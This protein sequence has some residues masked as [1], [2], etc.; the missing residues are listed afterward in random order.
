[1]KLPFKVK[2]KKRLSQTKT[3]PARNVEKKF[4]RKKENDKGQ[5]LLST[6]RKEHGRRNK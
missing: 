5:K 6:Q 4:L 1:M 2:E 3:C